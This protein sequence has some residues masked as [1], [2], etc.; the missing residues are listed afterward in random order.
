[1]KHRILLIAA[2]TALTIPATTVAA[3]S[4]SD[5]IGAVV[6]SQFNTHAGYN[7]HGYDHRYDDRYQRISERQAIRIAQSQGIRVSSA[8]RRGPGY[9]LV[10]RDRSG[11]R[12]TLRVDA[13]TGQI[14]RLDRHWDRRRDDRWERDDRRDDRRWREHR[15]DRD[16]DDDD[17]D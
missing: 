10:G 9:D 16:D 17:D 13:R 14:V 15:R 1:M 6:Q 3:Q 8:N 2:T 4:W 7:S 12:V 11:S 5:I